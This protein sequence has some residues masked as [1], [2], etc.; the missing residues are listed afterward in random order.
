MQGVIIVVIAI[1]LWYPAWINP[2]VASGL[3]NGYLLVGLD[4]FLNSC[5]LLASIIAFLIVLFEGFLLNAIL[6]RHGMIQNNT[7]LPMFMY[8][9]AMSASVDSLS[10]TPMVLVNAV[11]LGMLYLMLLQGTVP[12]VSPITIFS[13]AALVSISVMLYFPSVV[14]LVPLIL[15]FVLYSL[16]RWHYLLMLLMGLLAPFLLVYTCF[17]LFDTLPQ[18]VD[19]LLS[20]VANLKI[21]FVVVTWQQFTVQIA[22]GVMLLLGLV[23]GNMLRTSH[24]IVQ[25]KNNLVFVLFLLASVVSLFYT[26]LFPFNMQCFAIVFAYWSSLL[27]LQVNSRHWLWQVLFSLFL[28]IVVVFPLVG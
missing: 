4:N 7:L 15:V 28:V 19:R 18:E 16:Y 24:L 26:S 12:A 1:L 17:F 2:V 23:V 6:Y 20:A 11:V 10:F 9:L 5:P 27:L 3:D 25:D 8:V 22:Y 21:D 13:L 14:L